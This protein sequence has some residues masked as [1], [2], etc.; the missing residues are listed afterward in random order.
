MCLHQELAQTN[1]SSAAGADAL[2]RIASP[3]FFV[4]MLEERLVMVS[5]STF[6]VDLGF[7]QASFQS[8]SYCSLQSNFSARHSDASLKM[9]LDPAFTVF[10]LC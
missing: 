7:D 6:A 3:I 4:A 9:V 10:Y 1:V 8:A 2:A 5:T